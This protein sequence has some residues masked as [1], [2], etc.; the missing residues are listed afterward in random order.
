MHVLLLT[1]ADVFAGTERHIFDLASSLCTDFAGE[2]A[3]RVACPVPSPLEEHCRNADIDVIAIPKRGFIDWNAVRLLRR[4]L[5]SGRLDIIHAHNGRTALAAALAVTL[6]RRGQLVMTQHFLAPNHTGQSGL[7][8]ALSGAAHRWVSHRVTM[9]IAISQAVRN[10]MLERGQAAANKIVIVLNGVPDGCHRVLDLPQAVRQKFDVG[11]R[12]MVICAS[13]LGAEKGIE[14]LIAAIGIV[15]RNAP[16]VLC[17]IAGE[18]TQRDE[19]Q[20]QIQREQL[21]ENVR[22]IGFQKDVS[23]LVNAAD[24]FVLPSPNEP[25]GL[26]LVEAM[27]LGKAVVATCAGGPLEIVDNGENGVLVAPSSPDNLAQ[28]IAHLL[29]DE[30]LRNRLGEAARQRYEDCF[31]VQRM[32]REIADIYRQ[33]FAG[34]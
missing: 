26:S 2:I 25:F 22:L 6:A 24:V 15:S 1:D 11:A 19:L 14:T 12:P 16:D 21:E 32:A 13:R 8:G 28:A 33:A 9:F 20:E 29:D 31:T 18:G 34:K 23:S 17:L 30:E 10:A 3:V 7:Q 5:K 27:S 4:L